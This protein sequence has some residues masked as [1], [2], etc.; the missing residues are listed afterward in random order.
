VIFKLINFFRGYVHIK[1]SNKFVE[2][3]INICTYHNL[4][5][6]DIVREDDASVTAYLSRRAFREAGAIA[7]KANVTMEVL[8]KG[9]LPY[10][11]ARYK[12]RKAFAAG[13]L[14][15]IITFAYLMSLVWYVEVI[16]NER[17]PTEELLNEVKNSGIYIGVSKGKIDRDSVIT[18]MMLSR[19]DLSWVGIYVKGTKVTVHV[20][21]R[22]LM[23]PAE[24]DKPPCDIVAIKDGVV[25]EVIV[26]A[27][28][29]AVKE[30]D[31]V[32]KGD[33][34]IKGDVPLKFS[35]DLLHV[36]ARG[37]VYAVTWYDIKK[38][39]PAYKTV[40]D[41]TG[42]TY[43]KTR[44]DIFGK[45]VYLPKLSNMSYAEYEEEV[46]S[47][48]LSLGQ[49]V[50]LP[51]SVTEYRFNEIQTVQVSLNEE[52]AIE[53]CVSLIEEEAKDVIPENAE[54]LAKY[55][56]YVYDENGKKYVEMI[57]EC[58]ENIGVTVVKAKG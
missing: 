9:G 50:Y 36:H 29:A 13:A 47:R 18:D 23:P 21:E 42:K 3:F 58:K 4:F 24:D 11:L 15:F 37:E 51:V 12:K 10:I 17:I 53:Y 34:L 20:T 22:D 1:I 52:E 45:S 19:D 27:G 44:I 8:K 35:G 2:R 55:R 56:R 49:N 46:Q 26:K 41:R 30:G 33:V 38:E 48:T 54:V 5:L 32:F 6:W 39:V 43:K 31:S 57:Y 7:E 16:G 28:I 25:K 40:K 14:L